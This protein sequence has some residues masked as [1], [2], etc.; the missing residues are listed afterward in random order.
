MIQEYL[1]YAFSF[2]AVVLAISTIIQ[3]NPVYSAAS[4][5][6]VMLMLACN[7]VLLNAEFI[8]AIQVIVY[9]GAIMVLF[10]FVIMLLNIEYAKREKL[11]YRGRIF[12]VIIG[13]A[14]LLKLLIVGYSMAIKIQQGDLPVP[15]D[16]DSTKVVG[17]YLFSNYIL[18]F[19]VISVVLLIGI[20]GAV[21]LGRKERPNGEQKE[22][23]VVKTIGST[24]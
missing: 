3:K 8:A 4:L 2:L 5:I 9:V 17:K 18:P 1:G 19:E 24:H 7:Y 6:G 11:Y 23:V 22:E 20:I 15:K 21:V 14:L 12:G 16:L 10:V 13:V